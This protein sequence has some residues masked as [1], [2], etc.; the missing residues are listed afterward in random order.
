MGATHKSYELLG[1]WDYVS[2]LKRR[3]KV[4]YHGFSFRGGTELLER[5]LDQHPDAE[6]VQLQ[7]NYADWENDRITSRVNY[8]VARVHGIPI[9]VMEP[10][11][12][13]ALRF[14]AFV[15]YRARS[16]SAGMRNP[17]P[18]ARYSLH[19]QLGV[20]VAR[21]AVHRASGYVQLFLNA[22]GCVAPSEQ[23]EH[24]E[25]PLRKAIFLADLC[26][27]FLEVHGLFLPG[28]FVVFRPR[29]GILGCDIRRRSCIDICEFTFVKQVFC[30]V[31]FFKRNRS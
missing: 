30:A 9:V 8:K 22:R 16:H 14:R 6:F 23:Y 7:I 31:Y 24:L 5:T 19:A 1:L 15:V 13:G 26:Y 17:G 2:D 4:R 21:M 10:V 27:G 3:G 20:D 11:K 29:S 25:F 18:L 28:R 12:G